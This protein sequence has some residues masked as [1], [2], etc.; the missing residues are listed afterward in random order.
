MKTI[1]TLAIAVI[2]SLTSAFAAT[3][4]V[5]NETITVSGIIIDNHCATAHKDSLATFTASHTKD[6]VLAPACAA[7]GFSIY[8]ADGM[9]MAFD[10]SSNARI[11]AFLEKPANIL[12]VTVTG[13][14][15]KNGALKLV[16]IKNMK[17]P[18]AM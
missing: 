17:A 10:K 9:L 3:N 6:C 2:G 11:K 12:Q 7:S 15:E 14:K 8:T 18:T 13:I 4:A 16:S 5:K 1:M